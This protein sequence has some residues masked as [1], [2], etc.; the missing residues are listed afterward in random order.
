MKRSARE[1]GTIDIVA[2]A[3]VVWN[4]IIEPELYLVWNT[5]FMDYVIIDEKKEKVGT[6]YYVV[7]EKVG[8]LRKL[9]CII[10]EWVEKRK[11][12]FIAKSEA[13]EAEACYTI[14]PTEGRCRVTFEEKLELKGLMAEIIDP[15]FL[16]Q[17]KKKNIEECLQ[18]LKTNVEAGRL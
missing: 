1:K 14:E 17:E 7:A 11:F 6:T 4:W 5:D 15:L 2:P 3:E 18:K 13:V 8:A 9:D 12:A 10:T 16:E